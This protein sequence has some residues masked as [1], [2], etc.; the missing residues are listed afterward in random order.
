MNDPFLK[1]WEYFF[2]GTFQF[3]A[4]FEKMKKYMKN[5]KNRHPIQFLTPGINFLGK[6]TPEILQFEKIWNKFLGFISAKGFIWPKGGKKV[7]KN[8]ISDFSKQTI[9][10]V[11]LYGQSIPGAKI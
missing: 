10:D 4:N 3:S 6:N 11:F 1:I 7:A 8:F 9:L 5:Y 2:S